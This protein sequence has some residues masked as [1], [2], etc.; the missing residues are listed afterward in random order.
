MNSFKNLW[1][2]G[3]G[4]DLSC[5]LKTGYH[6]FLNWYKGTPNEIRIEAYELIEN[7]KYSMFNKNKHSLAEMFNEPMQ[8]D[9]DTFFSLDYYV[10]HYDKSII[11]DFKN[12]EPE[13]KEIITWADLELKLGKISESSFFRSHDIFGMCMDDLHLSLN[14]YLFD[15]DKEE[16]KKSGGSFKKINENVCRIFDDIDIDNTVF[17]ILNYT[18]NF[19][20]FIKSRHPDKTPNLVY[21]HGTVDDGNTVLGIGS[22]T[23]IFNSAFVQDPVVRKRLLKMDI[24]SGERNQPYEDFWIFLNNNLIFA[25]DEVNIFGSSMGGSDGFLW[26]SF[27]G[28]FMQKATGKVNVYDAYRREYKD[29]YG[30]KHVFYDSEKAKRNSIICNML[31]FFNSSYDTAEI[32][33]GVMDDLSSTTE[34]YIT[35]LEQRHV[36]EGDRMLKKYQEIKVNGDVNEYF[37]LIDKYLGDLEMEFSEIDSYVDEIDSIIERLNNFVDKAENNEQKDEREK[38]YEKIDNIVNDEDVAEFRKIIKGFSKT[39]ILRTTLLNMKP[40]IYP[41]HEEPYKTILYRLSQESDSNIKIHIALS[42]EKLVDGAVLGDHSYS[43]QQLADYANEECECNIDKA[44]SKIADRN[45]D[46]EYIFSDD[47]SEAD[48]ILQE[49]TRY[50]VNK[51]KKILHCYSTFGY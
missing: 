26:Y 18:K 9:K 31:F 30:Q 32:T 6:D 27:L 39:G 23:Q 10:G 4:F 25:R 22:E 8:V 50:A 48:Y 34:K 45:R 47:S 12:L 13:E 1:I 35:E 36:P 5:D 43:F 19:E 33:M 41:I 16:E 17:I 40:G 51:I 37:G 29:W 44:I 2:I 46:G 14:K 28:Q 3:N 11:K 42:R 24:T 21:L 20:R 7:K 15:V 38:S 49:T